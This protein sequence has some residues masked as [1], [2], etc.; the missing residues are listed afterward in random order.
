MNIINR[1]Y[2]RLFQGTFKIFVRFIKYP[3]PI[4]KYNLEDAIKPLKEKGYNHPLLLVSNS[5]LKLDELKSFISLAKENGINAEAYVKTGKEPTI[6]EIENLANVYKEFNCD[7]IIA[8]GGGSVLDAAKIMGGVLVSHKKAIKLR[9][10]QHVGKKLPFFVAVPTTAG[11][12]SEITV[13]A[14]VTDEKNND[15]FAVSDIHFIPDMVILDHNLLKTLPKEVIRNTGIDAYS[16]ALEAYLSLMA[17]KESD[18]YA[19]DALKLMKD[20][21]V[22]FYKDSKNEEARKNMHLASY[23]AGHAFTRVFVGYVH[24][25]SHAVGGYY[26]LPHG[27]LIAISL[28]YVLEAYGKKAYKKLSSLYDALFEGL[29]TKEEKA[30][31]MIQYVKD[32]NKELG[33]PE[34]LG[35]IIEANK[36]DELALHAVRE[37]N[38]SYPVPKELSFKEMKELL[39]KI[40]G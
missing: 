26:H 36:I 29:K 7:S 13:S 25:I 19:L 4:L 21:L 14:V 2:C 30:K 18:K 8:C 1:A 5:V 17:T 39:I 27:Y 28:P 40:N 16:H 10:M 20:N 15:K 34:T 31:Y 23:Y 35:T 3:N 38:P 37:A 11:T 33:Y 22:E 12:G 6:E 32:L 24:A 9:G